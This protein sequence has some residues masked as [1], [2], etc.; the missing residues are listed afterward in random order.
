MRNKEELEISPQSLQLE[1]ERR[2][3]G[4]QWAHLVWELLTLPFPVNADEYLSPHCSASSLELHL[5][6]QLRSHCASTGGNHSETHWRSHQEHGR[7][8]LR[9]LLHTILIA[10]NRTSPLK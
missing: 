5:F 7:A 2:G 8:R 3:K 6:R 9:S 1:T 10:Q 4:S